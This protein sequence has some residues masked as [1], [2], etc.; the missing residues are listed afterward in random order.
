MQPA[1]WPA[2]QNLEVVRRNRILRPKQ[3][4]GSHELTAGL[5]AS[6]GEEGSESRDTA[7]AAKALLTY[8]EA[9]ARAALA[10]AGTGGQDRH[11]LAPRRKEDTFSVSELVGIEPTPACPGR[12]GYVRLNLSATGA[13]KTTALSQSV[14]LR[15]SYQQ[16]RFSTLKPK[17]TS[18][19]SLGM[20]A[21]GCTGLAAG[22]W[23]TT[24]GP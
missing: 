18:M 13:Y 3:K 19:P 9:L 11:R 14:H 2:Q 15:R 7:S 4:G 8:D 16:G 23:H 1:R 20:L 5:S 12:A 6:N 10:R 22:R 24:R 21:F 17:T